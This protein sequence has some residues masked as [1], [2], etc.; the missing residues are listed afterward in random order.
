MRKKLS[1]LVIICCLSF[2]LFPEGIPALILHGVNGYPGN[3]KFQIEI[4]RGSSGLISSVRSYGEDGKM[5]GEAAISRNGDDVSGIERFNGGR[6]EF[7]FSVSPKQIRQHF[8]EFDPGA[9]KAS[10]TIN[11]VVKI[12]PAPGV[13]FETESRRFEVDDGCDLRVIDK[14][15]DESLYLFKKNLVENEGWY[16]ADWKKDGNC[17]TVHEYVTMEKYGEW[18]DAGS[19]QFEGAGIVTDDFSVAILNFCILDTLY[20]NN[21]TFLPFILGLKTGSY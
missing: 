8:I 1:L 6:T 12:A 11:R 15:T 4:F 14:E 13:L 7:L 9:H 16:K 20:S 2:A 5:K 10:R 3:S 19:S 17:T 21:A 18:V